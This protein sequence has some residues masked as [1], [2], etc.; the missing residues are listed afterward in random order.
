[1]MMIIIVVSY[2]PKTSLLIACRR[3]TREKVQN[4]GKSQRREKV[5]R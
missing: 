2:C 5:E 4:K 3:E 1:M